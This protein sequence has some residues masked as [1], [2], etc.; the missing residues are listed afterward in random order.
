MIDQDDHVLL[1]SDNKFSCDDYLTN[2]QLRFISNKLTTNG[3]HIVTVAPVAYSG[4]ICHAQLLFGS[5]V[6]L[7][8]LLF[9]AVTII[10]I[11]K[12]P[13]KGK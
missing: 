7:L 12:H 11:Q 1:S 2:S 6:F 3:W 10:V 5:M 8:L 4:E 9:L 13:A